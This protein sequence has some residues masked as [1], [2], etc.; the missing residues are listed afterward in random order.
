M[1]SLTTELL[2]SPSWSQ[3]V[4]NFNGGVDELIGKGVLRRVLALTD[5]QFSN[6]LVEAFW[7]QMK[8]QWLF[9]NTLDSVA[10]VRRHVSTYVA[11]HNGQIPHSAFRGQTPDEMYFGTGED[12]PGT[13]A[14]A[15]EAARKA[16]LHANRAVRCEECSQSDVAARAPRS[17][18]A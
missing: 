3:R 18:A 5:L 2:A 16:R 10:A 4:E 13:L 7:R 6:S 12:V 1:L 15:N 8:H 11:A 9:L 14:A 17:V